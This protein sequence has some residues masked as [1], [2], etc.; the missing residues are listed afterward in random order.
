MN[1]EIMFSGGLAPDFGLAWLTTFLHDDELVG[2]TSLGHSRSVSGPKVL[3]WNSR[4]TRAPS[5]WHS[6]LTVVVVHSY[7]VLKPQHSAS[8]ALSGFKWFT[9][10]LPTT[11]RNGLLQVFLK[12]LVFNTFEWKQGECFKNP[13]QR[14]EK[15]KSSNCQSDSII[16]IKQRFS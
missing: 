16:S 7:Q 10:I 3:L 6:F 8:C 14:K 15:Q 4:N 12:L 13:I 11:N 5:E 2:N 9:S 1:F